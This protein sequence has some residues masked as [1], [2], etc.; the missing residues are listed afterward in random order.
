MCYS[1]KKK[2]QLILGNPVLE[3]YIYVHGKHKHMYGVYEFIYP[4]NIYY[5]FHK[6][7]PII[8]NKSGEDICA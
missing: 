3:K 2:C 1:I 4:W 5:A 7:I 6:T 8:F